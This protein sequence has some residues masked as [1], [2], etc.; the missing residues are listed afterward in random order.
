MPEYEACRQIATQLQVPLKQIYA[1]AEL[2][3]AEQFR[4]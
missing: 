3:L 4:D 1:A 2:A